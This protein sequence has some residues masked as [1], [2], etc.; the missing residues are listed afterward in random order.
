M[1]SIRQLLRNK[2]GFT[3]LELLCTICIGSIVVGICLSMLTYSSKSNVSAEQTDELLYNGNFAIEYMKYEIQNA[4]KIIDCE[5]VPA[6]NSL[7]PNNI[8]LVV[9]EYQPKYSGVDKYVYFTYYIQNNRLYRLSKRFDGEVAIIGEAL[10]EKNELCESIESFGDT[11]IDWDNKMLYL[12]LEICD[13]RLED[14]FKST[15]LLNCSLDY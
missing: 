1:W 7:Y 15:I 3:L 6:L 5:N 8:G 4:D 14:R 2:K 11:Y 13:K 10:T 9:M 12:D